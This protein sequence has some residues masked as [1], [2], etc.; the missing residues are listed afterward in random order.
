LELRRRAVQP[1]VG[2]R[3]AA[4]RNGDIPVA[5]HAAVGSGDRNV[6]L[7]SVAGRVLTQPLERGLQAASTT[8]WA[9]A[10]RLARGRLNDEA[11]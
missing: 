3:R 5:R 2:I 8:E 6:A 9:T 10:K 1:Y 11:A 4:N 7:Q